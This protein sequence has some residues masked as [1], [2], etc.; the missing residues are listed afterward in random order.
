VQFEKCLFGVFLLH[1]RSKCQFI[2]ATSLA[3]LPEVY[4]QSVF[5]FSTAFTHVLTVFVIVSGMMVCKA[6]FSLSGWGTIPLGGLAAMANG[7]I[8]YGFKLCFLLSCLSLI[9]FLNRQIKDSLCALTIATFLVFSGYI[10]VDSLLPLVQSWSFPRIFLS[11]ILRLSGVSNALCYED[12][13]ATA[14]DGNTVLYCVGIE[15]FHPRFFL[16]SWVLYQ[17]FET[18]QKLSNRALSVL[19]SFCVFGIASTICAVLCIHLEIYSQQRWTIASIYL[20]IIVGAVSWHVL[21]QSMPKKKDAFRLMETIGDG[22]R[23]GSHL[24]SQKQ[25][26]WRIGE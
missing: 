8:G 7:E 26:Q 25:D 9:P 16:I 13:L 21:F 19:R 10:F 3:L 23:K 6:P 24:G 1:C 22:S 20:Q 2:F 4:D 17:F 18:A 12:S 15:I 11:W 5:E 14:I